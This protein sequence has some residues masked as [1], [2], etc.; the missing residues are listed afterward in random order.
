M[1]QPSELD[2]FIA[3]SN[4]LTGEKTLDKTLADQYLQRLNAQSPTSMQKILD[5][6]R[7]IAADP[8]VKFEVK[9][10]IVNT[11]DPGK[12]SLPTIAQQII[13]IWYTSEFF[14]IGPDGKL[15]AGTDGKPAASGGNQEQYYSGLIWKVIQAH[16]PTNSKQEYGYWTEKP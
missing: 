3:I 9:R 11:K 7:K 1:A 12:Q 2:L 14:Q 6:F 16:A 15:V 4:V 13:R 8:F 10:R 5:E